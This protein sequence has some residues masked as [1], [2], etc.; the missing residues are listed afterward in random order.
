MG[1]PDRKRTLERRETESPVRSRKSQ[2][3]RMEERKKP[4]VRTYINR[5]SKFEL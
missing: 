2:T 5:S 4:N 1:L 3:F